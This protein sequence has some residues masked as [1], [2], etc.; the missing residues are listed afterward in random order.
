MPSFL[1]YLLAAAFLLS[2]GLLKALS[3]NQA[4]LEA[5]DFVFGSEASL[6]ALLLLIEPTW[7][8]SSPFIH[9]EAWV[10]GVVGGAALLSALVT[11]YLGR[12]INSL[13]ARGRRGLPFWST[14]AASNAFGSVCIAL[15][16]W[17]KWPLH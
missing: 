9:K 4:D 14:W 16:V 17:A 1:P 5:E 6:A 2:S 7:D 8:G 10:P 13:A 3:R 11:A 15:T 12:V